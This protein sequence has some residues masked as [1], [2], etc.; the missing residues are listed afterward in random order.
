MAPNVAARDLLQLFRDPASWT[1]AR[2]RITHLLLVQWS[3]THVPNPQAGPNTLAGFLSCVPGGA[4]RWLMDHGISLAIESSAIKEWSCGELRDRSVVGLLET[5]HIIKDNGGSVAAVAMDEPATAAYQDPPLGCG[6]SPEQAAFETKVFV[7]AIHAAHPEVQIGLD[8]AYPQLDVEQIVRHMELLAAYDCKLPFFHLDVDFYRARREKK[9]MR[10]DIGLLQRY[11][12]DHGIR[13]G[14]IV[15]GERGD[16]NETFGAD[17]QTAAH[18]VD[19]AIIFASQDDV[20]LQS[21][22]STLPGGAGEKIY[23]D[24]V[25]DREPNSHTGLLLD[26]LRRYGI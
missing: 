7:D 17:A 5:L 8:E 26:L 23:P 9:D 12:H 13:F 4:F 16:S 22:S 3:I 10:R 2:D 14:V 11:C 6:Y 18:D 15:W 21:W 1:S 25:P 24:C 19:R 20:V